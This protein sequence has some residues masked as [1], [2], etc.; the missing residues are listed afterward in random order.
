VTTL[1]VDP[2]LG[3]AL[4][5]YAPSGV[6]TWDM[7]V[8]EVKGKRRI[9][10]HALWSLVQEIL[11]VHEPVLAVVE[12]VHAM[13][14]QGVTSSFTFGRVAAAVEM[15][16]VAAGIPLHLVTPGAWKRLMGLSAD[17]D[18]SRLKASRLFPACAGQW[19]RKKDDGRAEAALLAYYGS[20]LT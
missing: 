19:A 8:L 6:L 1:G 12:D 16:L 9:D 4:A 20:R 7:P 11:A 18:A 3:G 5:V 13:P 10:M 14:K 17:K 2:G 15:A